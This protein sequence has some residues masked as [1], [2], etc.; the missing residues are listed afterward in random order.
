M[1]S[2]YCLKEQPL[3][4]KNRQL[5]HHLFIWLVSLQAPG[6]SAPSRVR[7]RFRKAVGRTLGVLP[8]WLNLR[9]RQKARTPRLIPDV[10]RQPLDDRRRLPKRG[11]CLLLLSNCLVQPAQ[12]RLDLPAFSR[13]AEVYRYLGSLV[14]AADVPLVLP[15]PRGEGRQPLQ[16]GN[17]QPSIQSYAFPQAL[18][19]FS[20]P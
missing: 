13:Q 1:C 7:G 18:H 4:P 8:H 16:E 3:F 12:R 20:R 19:C 15:V 5:S 10:L 6:A 14:Q 17:P 9:P 11:V 2:W